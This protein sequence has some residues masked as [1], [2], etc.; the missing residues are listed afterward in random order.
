[1]RQ[2]VYQSI[3]CAGLPFGSRSESTAPSTGT[4]PCCAGLARPGPVPPDTHE[5]VVVSCPLAVAV[6]HYVLKAWFGRFSEAWAAPLACLPVAPAAF[7]FPP[8]LRLA[9]CLGLRPACNRSDLPHA[10]ALL[11]GVTIDA[12][13]S[14]YWALSQAAALPVV[15]P[16]MLPIDVASVS[17]AVKT[18]F[19][20]SLRRECLRAESDAQ[21]LLAAG[22]SLGPDN[23]PVRRFRR[24]WVEPGLCTETGAQLLFR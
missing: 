22:N 3:P 19:A 2:R 8:P 9:L 7:V 20:D 16:V 15:P 11:R 21:V 23:D 10:F 18:A 1:M 14:R 24:L 4:C 13:I 12:L 5:H 17:A 6:W